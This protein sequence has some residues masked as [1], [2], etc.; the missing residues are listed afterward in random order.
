MLKFLT[1]VASLSSIIKR[2]SIFSCW[3]SL[4]LL[5]LL[6]FLTKL[7]AVLLLINLLSIF[8]NGVVGNLVDDNEDELVEE[9]LGDVNCTIL[10]LFVV[11]LTML[12]LFV[13]NLL[14]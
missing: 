14:L 13:V 9:D 1:D 8:T 3:E 5:L 4:E 11:D 10:P 12:S 2:G 6:L 7:V